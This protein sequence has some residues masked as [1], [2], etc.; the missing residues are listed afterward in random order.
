M[1]KFGHGI[2]NETGD[3]LINFATVSDLKI[4]NI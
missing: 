4:I 3:E 2:R 1:G